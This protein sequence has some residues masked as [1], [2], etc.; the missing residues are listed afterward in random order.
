MAGGVLEGHLKKM[1]AINNISLTTEKDGRIVSKGAN[2]LNDD[3]R[4]ASVYD[5]K[6]FNSVNVMLEIRNDAAHTDKPI[7]ERTR[8]QQ[9]IATTKLFITR[10]T[11]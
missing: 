8:A 6:E 4:R 5:K 3:L 10:Y 2:W 11:I 1:C 9:L 7:V